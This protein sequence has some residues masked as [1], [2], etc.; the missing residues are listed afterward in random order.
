IKELAYFDGTAS[1]QLTNAFTEKEKKTKLTPK[2]TDNK[3]VILMN[4]WVGSPNHN[5]DGD[6][7]TINDYYSM[8][9]ALLCVVTGRARATYFQVKPWDLAGAWPILKDLGLEFYGYNTSSPL[10]EV[11]PKTFNNNWKPHE[12]YICCKKEDFDYLQS[13]ITLRS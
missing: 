7:I 4:N 13:V 8:A 12:V 11:S 9:F 5:Y 2:A 10:N 6:K 3:S 1:Y